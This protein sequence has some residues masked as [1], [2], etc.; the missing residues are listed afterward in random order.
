MSLQAPTNC[1]SCNTL[2]ATSSTGVDLVC[3][4]T[5]GCPAQVIGRL[6]YFCQRGLGNITGLSEKQIQK[7]YELYDVR[8]VADLF[9]LPMEEIAALEGFGQKSV[10]NL[11]ESIQK[12]RS[13][14]DYKFLAGLGIEGIGV[15][16]AKLICD[17]IATKPA[18]AK[19]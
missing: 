6:S 2:L 4:N 3:P 11:E 18:F 13:I 8:D 17:L 14:T 5:S 7:F 9:D 12:A 16:V 19:N 1:P 10:S 15:E